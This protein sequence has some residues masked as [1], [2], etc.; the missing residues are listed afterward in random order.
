[1]IG[2]AVIHTIKAP[3]P[4]TSRART[5]NPAVDELP[6][7]LLTELN[8]TERLWLEALRYRVHPDYIRAKQ[9]RTKEGQSWNMEGC[10]HVA[11]S[12]GLV[13]GVDNLKPALRPAPILKEAWRS[14]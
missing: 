6:A 2:H 11:N 8:P 7:S 4:D 10:G 1:M 13:L 9:H 3:A 12:V 14:G 5:L